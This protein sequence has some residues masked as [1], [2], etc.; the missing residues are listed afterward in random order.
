ME[1]KTG[2]EK[3]LSLVMKECRE[4]IENAINTSNLPPYLL[5]PI[6]KDYYNQISILAHNMTAEEENAYLHNPGKEE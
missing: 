4:K 5:E 3:P 6:L 1:N 2:N